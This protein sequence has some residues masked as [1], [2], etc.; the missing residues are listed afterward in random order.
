MMRHG[1]D[2]AL[3]AQPGGQQRMGERL[4][5]RLHIEQRQAFALFGNEVPVL[6]LI[7]LEREGGLGA[8]FGRQRRQKV[9]RREGHD[10]GGI[11]AVVGEVSR[12]AP[13]VRAIRRRNQSLIF[14]APRPD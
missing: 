13:M 7:G 14:P 5:V 11:D 6:A 1:L 9:L 3:L 8:L 10:S 12:I 4:L 2:V